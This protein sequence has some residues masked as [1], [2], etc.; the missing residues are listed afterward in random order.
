LRAA[1]RHLDRYGDEAVAKAREMV[2]TLKDHGDN[3]GADTWLRMIVA[4]ETN[5]QA[6]SGP[7]RST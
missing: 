6:P 1:H 2:R 5:A 3:D 7:H 4:L